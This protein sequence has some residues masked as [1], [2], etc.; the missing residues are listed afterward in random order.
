MNCEYMFLCG[1]S[2]LFDMICG[3][4]Y[5]C[6]KSSTLRLRSLYITFYLRCKCS[7]FVCARTPRNEMKRSNEICLF[8]QKNPT[9][10]NSLQL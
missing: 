7:M 4:F 1:V 5:N 8:G 10:M 3:K 2:T 9:I 6:S